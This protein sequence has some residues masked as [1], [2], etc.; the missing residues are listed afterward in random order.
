MYT[1]GMFLG[2]LYTKLILE[3]GK[4]TTSSGKID[5]INTIQKQKISLRL[6]LT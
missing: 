6:T 2:N 1:Y 3:V 4:F 5:H